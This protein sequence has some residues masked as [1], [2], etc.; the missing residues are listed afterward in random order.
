[1]KTTAKTKLARIIGL[2]LVAL[3]LLTP[4]SAANALEDV[5]VP[6][7]RVIYEVFVRNFSPAGNLKGVEAQVPRLKELGVDVIWLMPIYKLGDVGKWGPYSSP[8]AVKDYKAIDPM[9]GSA[10]DLHDLIDAIHAA[11]M[12]VWFDWVGNHT[13][14]DNVWVSQHP[15][16]YQ[17]KNGNFVNPNGWNDVY[18]L[19]IDNAAMHEAMI[20]AM[21]Y[22]VT[23]FDIDG[24]RCDY[25]S[26]PSQEFWAKATSR[27]L[28]DGK[29]IAWLA[30]DDAEPE[31]VSNGWFDYNWTWG[32]FGAMEKYAAG[33]SNVDALRKA[34]AGLHTDSRYFGRSRVMYTSSHDV[35]QDCDKGDAVFGNYLKPFVVLQFTVYGCP[36]IYNGQEINYIGGKKMLC[37]KSPINW[38]NPDAD[39]TDLYKKL[40]NLKHTHPSLRTGSQSASYTDLDNSN[41]N[42]ILSFRRGSG[43]NSIVVLLNLKGSQS[44]FTVENLPAGQFTD[45]ISGKTSDFS[46]GKSFTLPAYGYAVFVNENAGPAET[47]SVYVHNNMGWGETALYAWG[48]AEALGGWPGMRPTDRVEIDGINYDKFELPLSANGLNLNLIYNNNAKGTQCS[49]YTATIDKDY[50]LVATD[51]K[52]IPLSE[53]LSGV[54]NIALDDESNSKDTPVYFNLNGIRVDQPSEGIYVKVVGSKAS[55]VII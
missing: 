9:N 5:R 27:V 23:E 41:R 45:I 55:K 13:S 1:M 44:S 52:L 6:E 15:E 37:D 20:D 19:D 10:Q 31:L 26:G 53:W 49:D 35:V 38:N 28:K 50:Y 46:T 16:Y 51:L 2:A 11:G 30:E 22:W 39:M 54:G 33:S 21:Q 24:Y 4:W 29:R 7:N 25:A 43:D 34:S 14:M 8:Y 42:S 18:Q 32:F 17:K 47:N 40:I 12:D 3:A 48:D 36:V